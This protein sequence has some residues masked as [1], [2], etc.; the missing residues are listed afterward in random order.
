MDLY[1]SY[2]SLLAEYGVHDIA[3]VA[4]A[5]REPHRYY[6][7]EVHLQKLLDEIA[8]LAQAGDL[9]QEEKEILQVVAFFHDWVYD[10][11]AT[12]NEEQSAQVF[13]QYAQE[14]E[15]AITIRDIIL[16]TKDHQ[17]DD[18]LGRVFCALDMRVVTHSSFIELLEWE[19][20]I[21]KEYQCF[22]YSLYKTGR[23]NILNKF[24]KLYP[25]NAQNL[26]ALVQ[27]VE[28]YKPRVGVYAGS[29]NPFH[30]G[31]LNILEKAEKIFD[32]VI[33]AQGINPE[34]TDNRKPLEL[35]TTRY[36][37][38]ETFRG[39]LTDYLTSKEK[40]CHVTLIRGLRN[41]ADLDY[42]INQWRFMEDM[43]PHLDIIFI[44][45]DQQFEHISSTAIKNL[46]RIRE[47]EG[48]KYLPA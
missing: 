47:G 22:D 16:A 20:Q 40:D 23:L 32:K 39:F 26:S 10:V 38:S 7:T 6:H 41:G 4:Q 24:I 37:Q 5:W 35:Q 34:K 1:V 28:Q 9:T 42:E 17:A 15:N 43:K 30:F 33:I 31:H 12:D 11:K 8:Q 21:F 27:Y 29:F 3:P 36:R 44:A 14:H 18:R 13:M 46:E 48:Q 25:E 45:C 19:R 2:S